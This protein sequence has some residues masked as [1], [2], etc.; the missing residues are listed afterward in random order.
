[1][2]SFPGRV[3]FWL[4]LA[5]RPKL[6]GAPPKITVRSHPDPVPWPERLQ[7]RVNPIK[8]GDVGIKKPLDRGVGVETAPSTPDLHQPRPHVVRRSLDCD[9][10]V[11]LLV[12]GNNS[13]PG[14]SRTSSESVAPQWVLTWI[15]REYTQPRPAAKKTAPAVRAMSLPM[16]TLLGLAYHPV[17]TV[18]PRPS[19]IYIPLGNKKPELD[20]PLRHRLSVT[21]FGSRC[22]ATHSLGEAW[23]HDQPRA[24][25]SHAR[26]A[27]P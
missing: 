16:W 22:R 13:S 12:S 18:R 19:R 21:S 26:P 15:N 2:A 7:A 27:A 6:T 1:V 8:V 14:S 3:L 11:V 10:Y 20:R 9:A 23:I 25:W 4:H 24:S 17:A 5:Y